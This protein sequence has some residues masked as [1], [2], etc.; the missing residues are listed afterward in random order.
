LQQ[1][2]L[3]QSQFLSQTSHYLRT[4]LNAIMGFG[5]LLDMDKSSPLSQRQHESV[6]E[7]NNPSE[8]LLDLINDILNLSQM[9]SGHIKLQFEA[10]NTY[11]LIAECEAL[12]STLAQA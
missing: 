12:I 5:Q 1:A 10:V 9:E 11:E 6:A 3:A 7:I 8:H 2:R 4:P